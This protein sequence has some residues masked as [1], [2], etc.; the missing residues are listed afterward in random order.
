VSAPS[1]LTFGLTVSGQRILVDQ[2]ARFALSTDG[3]AT[4]ASLAPP[5]HGGSLPIAADATDIVSLSGSLPALAYRLVGKGWAEDTTGLGSDTEFYPATASDAL[6]GFSRTTLYKHKAGGGWLAIQ[7]PL[8]AS[9]ARFRAVCIVGGKAYALFASTNLRLYTLDLAAGNPAWTP[10][11]ASAI[12]TLS[13]RDYLAVG[14]GRAYFAGHEEFMTLDLAQADAQWQVDTATL[15]RALTLADGKVYR[16]RADA[17]GGSQ[18]TLE[19][20]GSDGTW[21]TQ[22]T[23]R[24]FAR[25]QG[26]AL[27]SGGG[28]LYAATKLGVVRRDSGNAA[29][30]WDT[31]PMGANH[32]FFPVFGAEGGTLFGVSQAGFPLQLP[33]GATAWGDLVLPGAAAGTDA[34][35]SWAGGVLFGFASPPG[36]GTDTMYLR[37]GGLWETIGPVPSDAPHV[38]PAGLVGDEVFVFAF[39]NSGAGSFEIQKRPLGGG[40]WTKVGSPQSA[41]FQGGCVAGS[42]A[43]ALWRAGSRAISTLDLTAAG[44]AWQAIPDDPGPISLFNFITP[45]ADTAYFLTAFLSQSSYG[46]RAFKLSPSGLAKLGEDLP[47]LALTNNGWIDDGNYL[48]VGGRD[49][50]LK[51]SVKRYPLAGGAWQTV[52]IALPATSSVAAIA[53]DKGSQTLFVE[54]DEGL[55]AIP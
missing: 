24:W 28:K 18:P 11:G 44:A 17:H 52:P 51:A 15:D 16:Y 30:A 46:T 26:E 45:T 14:S 19:A 53:I 39:S 29:A 2:L 7:A 42:R 22:A 47:F 27:G 55:F 5:P 9:D 8:P 49:S 54:T 3:G 4:W 32:T 12:A 50:E 36:G 31:V 33:A 13:S 35:L 6:Y 38:A 48:Y 43:Y 10:T 21:A 37:R 20:L 1:Q 40:G 41:Y 25:E 23:P 34:S